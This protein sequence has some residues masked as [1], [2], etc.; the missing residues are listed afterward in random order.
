MIVTL[1]STY[2]YV[3]VEEKWELT[4]KDI[5]DWNE[6]KEEDESTGDA[7][8]NGY[9]TMVNHKIIDWGSNK[10]DI[11]VNEETSSKTIIDYLK[12]SK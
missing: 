9:G 1:H 10:G 12:N 6:R 11:I 8:L 2:K 3:V 4:D 7:V 5:T